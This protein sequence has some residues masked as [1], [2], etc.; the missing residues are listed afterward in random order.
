MNKK[1]LYLYLYILEIVTALVASS[2]V[3]IALNVGLFRTLSGVNKGYDSIPERMIGAVIIIALIVAWVVGNN[4][5]DIIY[6]AK[7]RYR[8]RTHK[9]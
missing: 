3:T 1:V 4:P 6:N 8:Y 5:C 9:H 2:A 7:R